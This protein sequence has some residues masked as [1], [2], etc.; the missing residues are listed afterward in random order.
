MSTAHDENGGHDRHR[1]RTP[2]SQLP[3]AEKIARQNLHIEILSIVL[4]LVLLLLVYS[5]AFDIDHWA[6][7][8]VFGGIVA[9]AIGAGVA[10]NTHGK[11]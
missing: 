2:T 11:A 8:I 4:L 7:W 6:E 10:I 9:T 1:F 5:A 3:H